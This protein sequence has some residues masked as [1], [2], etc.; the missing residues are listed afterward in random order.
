MSV[1][2]IGISSEGTAAGHVVSRLSGWQANLYARVYVYTLAKHL[3]RRV[4][5]SLHPRNFQPPWSRDM[6]AI[7][8]DWGTAGQ[9]NAWSGA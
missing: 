5:V 4:G 3:G 2:L 6:M 8:A 9:G 7:S 1:Y